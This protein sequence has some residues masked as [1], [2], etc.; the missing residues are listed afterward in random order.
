MTNLKK[1]LRQIEISRK[2]ST[3]ATH[4]FQYCTCKHLILTMWIIDTVG[5]AST[6]ST[7]VT[8]VCQRMSCFYHSYQCYCC[9]LT[10]VVLLPLLSVLL[11]SVNVC[12]AS[13]TPTSITVVY[14]RK[15]RIYKHYTRQDCPMAKHENN[16][17]LL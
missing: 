14:R 16:L 15:R 1:T 9:L 17:E 10:Y 13:T 12:R 7:S 11:L 4:L 2:L 8:D 5:R 6:T 3:Y